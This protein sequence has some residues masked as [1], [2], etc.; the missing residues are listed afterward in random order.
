MNQFRTTFTIN[1]AASK[2]TYFDS[3]MMLGSCFSENIGNKLSS[4]Q[5][6]LCLNPYGILY[7]P[8]SIEISIKEIVDC[9]EYINKDI[10]YFNDNWFSLKHHGVFSSPDKDLC[11]QKINEFIENANTYIK[12][13]KYIFITLG[14]AVVYFDSGTDF[15]VGNC[16]K[17]PASNFYTKRL[18][19]EECSNSLDNI[20]NAI[21][22]V[23]EDVTVVFTVSPIRHWKDGAVENQRS[24]ATLVL[25]IDQVIQ[26]HKN[27]IY[28]PSYEIMM[29]DLRDYRFYKDDMLH[30]GDIAV[31]YIW[32]KFKNTFIS[33]TCFEAMDEVDKIN[34]ALAHRVER[35]DTAEYRKFKEYIVNKTSELE[36][37]FPYLSF[38][39]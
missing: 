6:D 29:D 34:K 23:N 1:E 37:K 10:L 8:C 22:A 5:F 33:E 38:Q 27:I 18:S 31:E 35:T 12:K 32:E 9:K 39:L 15:V 26:H 14:T 11:L 7:N 21:N 19:V 20:V 30:V 25:A 3:L 36:K 16:H 13:S 24:K 28:F 4:L 17:I 2:I